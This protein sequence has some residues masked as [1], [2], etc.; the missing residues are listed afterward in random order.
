MN[1]NPNTTSVIALAVC[2]VAAF[3]YAPKRSAKI[4]ECNVCV[5]FGRFLTVA[6]L[7]PHRQLLAAVKPT[8]DRQ[9]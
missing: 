2:R 1:I 8:L 6:K 9:T 5:R 4:H 3:T 7:S